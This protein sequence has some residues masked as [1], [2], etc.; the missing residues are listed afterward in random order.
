MNEFTFIKGFIIMVLC[1]PSL[2]PRAWRSASPSLRHSASPSLR[3]SSPCLF[4][5]VYLFLN[6]RVIK[7]SKMLSHC[8]NFFWLRQ[9]TQGQYIVGNPPNSHVLLCLGRKPLTP[10][11]NVSQCRGSLYIQP[12]SSAT[13]CKSINENMKTWINKRVLWC[14]WVALELKVHL[15]P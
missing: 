13:I 9:L 1:S 5:H 2:R 14:C 15:G 12:W 7:W 6:P 4:Q 8:A 11:R 10:L 3:P